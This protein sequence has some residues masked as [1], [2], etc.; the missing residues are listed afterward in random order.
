MA[1]TV[2]DVKELRAAYETS[3][4]DLSS[5]VSYFQQLANLPAPDGSDLEAARERLERAEAAYRQSRDTLAEF[6]LAH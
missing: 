6:I 3:F 5:Q 1:S 2:E 4:H